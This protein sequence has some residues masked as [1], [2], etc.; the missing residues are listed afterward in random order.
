VNCKEN[1]SFGIEAEYLLVCTERYEPLWH[2]KLD[3]HSLESLLEGIPVNDLPSLNGL[4][5]KS[6]SGEILPYY[7]EGYDVYDAAGQWHCVQPKGLELRT[8]ISHSIPDAVAL[9]QRLQKRLA[10]AT[11]QQG[12]SIVALS[13]HPTATRFNGERQGRT[14]HRWKWAQEAM[15]NYAAHVNV[16]VPASIRQ[17]FDPNDFAAKV[18]HYGPALTAISAASPLFAGAPWRC[19]R[20]YGRSR[21]IFRRCQVAPPFVYHPEQGHRLEFKAFDMSSSHED[22]HQYLLLWLALILDRQLPGRA[23]Q[24]AQV[25]AMQRAALDGLTDLELNAR[26]MEVLESAVDTLP[27][28]GFDAEPLEEVA[29]RVGQRRSRADDILDWLKSGFVLSDV[30]A[31]LSVEPDAAVLADRIIDEPTLQDVK[32][33]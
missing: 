15:F 27:R 31:A 32:L 13:H 24:E 14:R 11:S 33:A 18:N 22:F 6:P 4:V 5:S 12:M 25:A 9:F 30:L 23:D 21:R 8:P 20:R 1:F 3:S 17:S 29:R 10:N 19:D 2:D 26:A 28:F 7:V 16:S